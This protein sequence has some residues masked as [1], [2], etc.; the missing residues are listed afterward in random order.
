MSAPVFLGSLH[1]RHGLHLPTEGTPERVPGSVRRTVTTDMLRPD[2]LQGMLVLAGAARDL[3][4]SHEGV[5]VLGEARMR[6]EVDY[7]GSELHALW[8][9]PE[10]PALRQ[11][12]GTGAASGFRGR[13]LAADPELPAECSLLHQMLDD[14]PVTALVSGHSWRNEALLHG[15]GDISGHRP[16]FGR[17]NCAGF[18]DGGTM[19]AEVDAT[20]RAPVV[21]GPIAPSLLTADPWAWHPL[22][23]LPSHGMRRARRTDVRPGP[24]PHVDVLFRDS[25]VRPDGCETV[26]HEYTVTVDIDGPT[27]TIRSILAT[28]Q[29]LPWVECPAAAASAQR[30]VGAPLAGLRKL[31]RATFTG[32]STCTHLN[33]TLRSLE[34]VPEL[35]VQAEQAA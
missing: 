6:A 35:L 18:A 15:D 19:M 31:V 4:T 7:Q 11:V 27:R 5:S 10:R 29:V 20:G 22:G 30:L 23:T 2:G 16:L 14:I 13:V 12:I 32:V 24:D 28:P 17:D 25:Y 34:D 33:D 9:E 26:I 3:R 8:T 21:T 1:P